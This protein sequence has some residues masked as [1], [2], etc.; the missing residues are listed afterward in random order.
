MTDP[1]L[2]PMVDR[3]RAAGDDEAADALVMLDAETAEIPAPI[4]APV[5]A[6]PVEVTAPATHH[7]RLEAAL[8]AIPRPVTAEAVL[9]AARGILPR[10]QAQQFEKWAQSCMGELLGR[11]N[12]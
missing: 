8:Q 1:A 11:L 3:L 12:G 7:T 5:A 9:S 10:P 2:Q 4:V 6:V